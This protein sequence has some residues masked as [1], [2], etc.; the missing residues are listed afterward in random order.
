MTTVYYFPTDHRAEAS[1]AGHDSPGWRGSHQHGASQGQARQH[2][3]SNG[4]Q[5]NDTCLHS[6][7]SWLF[8]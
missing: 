4:G 7:C 6:A 8:S 3:T 1:G 2:Q 5:G